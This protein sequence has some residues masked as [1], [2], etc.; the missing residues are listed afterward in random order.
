MQRDFGDRGNRKHARLKYTIEDRGLDWFRARGRAAPGLH[1]LEPAR[2]FR[3]EHTGDRYGWV[4]DHAG[5]WHYTLFIE[6]GRVRD[7]PDRP[8][9]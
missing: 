8:M 7:R 1:A 9:R 2:P 5:N 4:K 6:N 3:F